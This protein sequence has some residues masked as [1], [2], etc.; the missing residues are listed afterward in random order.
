MK[1]ILLTL[2]TAAC[3]LSGCNCMQHSSSRLVGGDRDKHGCIGSAGYTWSH[4]R[5]DCIRIFE[6]G[7]R[8]HSP[9][10]QQ[11]DVAFIVFS[12]DKKEVELFLPQKRKNVILQRREHFV[13]KGKKWKL[14]QKD[15]KWILKEKGETVYLQP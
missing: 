3:L 5:K 12:D 6:E 4:V 2:G 9:N 10:T 15:N 1:K 13:W 8:L 11:T 14:I 7:I